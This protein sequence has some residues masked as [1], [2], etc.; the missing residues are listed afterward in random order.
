MSVTD[1]T[2][3]EAGGSSLAQPVVNVGFWL[4]GCEASVTVTSE[5][6]PFTVEIVTAYPAF[7]PRWMLACERLTVTHSW[8][9][10]LEPG[11]GLGLPMV[12]EVAVVLGLPVTS[13]AS[14][15]VV[16][17]AADCDDEAEAEADAELDWEADAEAD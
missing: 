14:E 9:C 16:V 8:V 2:V 15:A 13:A 11:L 12:L 4:V 17:E 3:Q 1:L 7:W 6:E 10:E 5:A